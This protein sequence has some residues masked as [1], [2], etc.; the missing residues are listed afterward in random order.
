M[1]DR[2]RLQAEP[3][4]VERDRRQGDRGGTEGRRGRDRDDRVL[5]G[6]SRVAEPEDGQ[7]H[8]GR[9]RG[10]RD[11][12]PRRRDEV[13]RPADG[14][15]ELREGLGRPEGGSELEELGARDVPPIEGA[16][17]QHQR[18]GLVRDVRER[19]AGEGVVLGITSHRRSVVEEVADRADE[20]VDIGGTLGGGGRPK[21]V[22]GP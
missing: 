9:E 1:R 12:R 17:H 21:D 7:H 5:E 22:R 13:E 14:R 20:D 2:R 15:G 18:L 6:G 10:D 11:P 19:Q 16:E 8:Q 3:H 4:P